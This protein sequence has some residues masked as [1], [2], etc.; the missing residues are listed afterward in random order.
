MKS[1]DFQH[2]LGTYFLKRLLLLRTTGPLQRS[3]YKSK[4]KRQNG[5]RKW[6]WTQIKYKNDNDKSE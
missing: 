3:S 2:L 4:I 6:K 5:T 1:A